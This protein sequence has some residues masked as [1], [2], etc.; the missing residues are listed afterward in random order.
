MHNIGIYC[1]YLL[2]ANIFSLIG[3]IMMWRL[4]KIGIFIYT[5]AELSTHF[6]HVDLGLPEQ[7]SNSYMGLIFGV[8][9]DLVFIVMYFTNI[10]FMNKNNNNTFIQSGT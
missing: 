1:I 8:L 4:E 9:I 2:I 3:V 6:F 7:E 5:I 10:K